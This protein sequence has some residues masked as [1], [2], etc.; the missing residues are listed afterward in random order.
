[1]KNE[2]KKPTQSNQVPAIKKI[3]IQTPTGDNKIKHNLINNV[4]ELLNMYSILSVQNI[5]FNCGI[6]TDVKNSSMCYNIDLIK[7]KQD[8]ILTLYNELNK[9]KDLKLTFE[10]IQ[11]LYYELKK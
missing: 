5:G 10:T 9:I 2:N 4:R 1:M 11:C 3:I 6:D 8:D 7:Y